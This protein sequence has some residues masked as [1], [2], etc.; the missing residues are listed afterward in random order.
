MSDPIIEI[1]ANNVNTNDLGIVM[2]RHSHGSTDSNV[3]IVY[4]ESA[5]TLKFGYTDKNANSHVITFEENDIL[6]VD[7]NG[8]LTVGSNLTANSIASNILSI[9]GNVTCTNIHVNNDIHILHGQGSRT[10]DT[11]FYSSTDSAVY[12]NTRAGFRTSLN[13]PTRTGGDASGSWSI[14]AATATA[15][16]T[17]RTIGG[18]SFDAVSYTHLTLPT[19]RIV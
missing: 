12:K 13:V 10:G 3:A 11:V 4:D 2:S 17:A 9:E 14:N 1:G 7:I 5:K 16:A 19:K 15:L 18:V 8:S 6:P